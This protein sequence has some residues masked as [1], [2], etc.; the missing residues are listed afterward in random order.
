MNLL[1]RSFVRR[2]DVETEPP[3]TI[4]FKVLALQAAAAAKARWVHP[5]IF[6]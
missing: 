2:S 1:G 4:H 5:I 6:L 3:S